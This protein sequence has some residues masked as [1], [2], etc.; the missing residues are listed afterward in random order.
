MKTDRMMAGYYAYLKEQAMQKERDELLVKI[1]TEMFGKNFI[2]NYS[3]LLHQ[4]VKPNDVKFEV[5]DFV[6]IK[7][8]GQE[9]LI[10][11]VNIKGICTVEI[12][13]GTFELKELK[14][15]KSK[16]RLIHKAGEVKDNTSD[17]LPF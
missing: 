10:I 3:P 14:M 12:H 15:S 16:L 11:S 5:G 17:I 6:E 4:S 9:A 2:M 8:T 13:D 7:A 1:G